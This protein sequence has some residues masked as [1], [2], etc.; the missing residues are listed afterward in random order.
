MVKLVFHGHSCWEVQGSKHRILI[1]PYLTGNPLADVKP[2]DFSRLD[3][4]LLSHGH[5]DHIGD[6]PAERA[7]AQA[8]IIERSSIERASA[9][10]PYAHSFTHFDLTLHPLVIHAAP[11]TAVHDGDRYCWYEPRQP[12]RIG[13]AKPAVE[14]IRALDAQPATAMQRQS[15]L[16]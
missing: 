5:G 9:M 1:D 13:L 12:A 2:A 14:L 7:A 16:L 4:I 15:S 3:A 8:W 10:E 11:I 6:Q